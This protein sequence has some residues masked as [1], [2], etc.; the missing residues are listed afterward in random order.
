[1]PVFRHSL[2]FSLDMAPI[3]NNQLGTCRELLEKVCFRRCISQ[4]LLY[5][6]SCQLWYR[7]EHKSDALTKE[8]FFKERHSKELSDLSFSAMV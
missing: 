2:L 6:V 5:Q 7:V 3:I 4:Y 8:R 1:M